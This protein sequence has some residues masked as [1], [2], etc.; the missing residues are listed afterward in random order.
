VH[1][2]A[3]SCNGLH[4]LLL[5]TKSKASYKATNTEHRMTS[6]SIVC[7]GVVCVLTIISYF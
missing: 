1:G 4:I 3:V 7:S 6:F 5:F 2:S